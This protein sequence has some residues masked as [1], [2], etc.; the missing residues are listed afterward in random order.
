M[1]HLAVFGGGGRTGALLL[2][3]AL[4]AGHSVAALARSPAAL[5]ARPGLTVIAGD[6]RE[7]GPV[8]ATLTG[9]EATICLIG[10]MN[11]KPHTDVS[12][13]TRVILAQCEAAGVRRAVFVT[14]IGTGDS[15]AP[16][17]SVPF[18]LIIRT[19]ARQIWA[20]R[21]RQE[22][23]IRASALD[24][25]IVRPG[26]LRDG[27]AT[28]GVIVAPSNGPFPKKIALTRADVAAFCLHAVAGPDLI[29]RT[30]CIYA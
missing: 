8:A 17:R 12:D 24:W 7:P 18:K 26:G 14:T 4:A 15:F 21:E 22:A 3:Q 30:V 11:R 6:A 23:L 16:M 2:E 13:A 28:G 29:R 20:D 5:A 1:M 27:P 10:V 9:A 25:T 19:V